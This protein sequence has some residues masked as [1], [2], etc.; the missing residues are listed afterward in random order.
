[1][2]C[3]TYVTPGL[4]R[5]IKLFGIRN[6]ALELDGASDYYIVHRFSNKC[7][8]SVGG[9]FVQTGEFFRTNCS[10]IFWQLH[11]CGP[12]AKTHMLFR[13]QLC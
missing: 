10:S 4:R 1:M 7:R 6:A 9:D 11:R 2:N 3:A 5:N 13:S 12:T 8:R